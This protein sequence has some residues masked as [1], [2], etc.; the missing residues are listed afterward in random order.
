MVEKFVKAAES[1][2]ARESTEKIAVEN[3]VSPQSHETNLPASDFKPPWKALT[4]VKRETTAPHNGTPPWKREPHIEEEQVI[5]AKSLA[6]RL[7][8][9]KSDSPIPDPKIYLDRSNQNRPEN[10]PLTDE[11][12]EQ[13]K[14]ETGWPPEIIDKIA[15]WKEYEIYKKAGLVAVEING[16]WCLIRTDIDW[17]Q[18]DEFGRTNKERAEQGLAPLDKNGKSIELHHIGQTPDSPLAELTQEEHR[19]TGNDSILHDKNQDTKIDR[20][21]FQVE[22]QDHWKERAKQN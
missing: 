20:S 2:V 22:K 18:K 11:Q 16:K 4:E 10:P 21:V 19:G 5:D 3:R 17:E 8:W 13:I 9:G 7:P 12:K 6:F 14:A 1:W 15:S